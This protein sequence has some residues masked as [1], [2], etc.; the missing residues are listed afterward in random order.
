M[1]GCMPCAEGLECGF[2]AGGLKMCPQ[3]NGSVEAGGG[4]WRRVGGGRGGASGPAEG[5][6]GTRGPRLARGPGGQQGAGA[7]KED[8]AGSGFQ[9]AKETGMDWIGLDWARLDWT[10]LYTVQVWQLWHCCVSAE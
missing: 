1:N 2:R 7:A 5:R 6:E 10:G 4:R 8:D 9:K 3:V